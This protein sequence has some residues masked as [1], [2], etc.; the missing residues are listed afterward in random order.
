MDKKE[1]KLLHESLKRKAEK[2]IEKQFKPQKD[3]IEYFIANDIKLVKECFK[4][5][6][7]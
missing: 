5:K 1:I 6:G 7:E 3:T 4:T 2:E